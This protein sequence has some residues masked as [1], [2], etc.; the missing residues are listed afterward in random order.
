VDQGKIPLPN[1]FRITS[2]C[3]VLVGYLAGGTE[4]APKLITDEALTQKLQGYK[5]FTSDKNPN[6]E[7]FAALP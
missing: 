3:G 7:D 6:A 5:C 4:L 1:S 2:R